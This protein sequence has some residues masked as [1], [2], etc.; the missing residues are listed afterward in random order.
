[1]ADLAYL[2]TTHQL[3]ETLG[4]AM[5][6]QTVVLLYFTAKWCGPC[7][8]IKPFVQ[9][10][11]TQHAGKLMVFAIDIDTVD[12]GNHKLMDHFDIKS[13]PTF[14]FVRNNQVVGISTGADQEALQQKTNQVL[15]S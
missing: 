11:Q 5:Q 15:H 8:K 2:L 13:V 1:M 9:Q 14:I 12:A 3:Q 10:L 7:K 4:K 6:T